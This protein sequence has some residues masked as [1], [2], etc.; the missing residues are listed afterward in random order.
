MLVGVVAGFRN[1]GKPPEATRLL[2]LLLHGLS[3][4]LF[5]VAPPLSCRQSKAA[6][7]DAVWVHV[8]APRC[9]KNAS[10]GS[11]IGSR[12]SKSGLRPPDGA[13]RFEAGRFGKGQ[14]GCLDSL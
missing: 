9:R 7:I 8:N 14:H 10:F 3:W 5:H 2:R 6:S 11:P 4:L 13:S 12:L 1:I